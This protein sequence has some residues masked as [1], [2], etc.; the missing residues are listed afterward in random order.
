MELT[1]ENVAR[2]LGIPA[3]RIREATDD[4]LRVINMELNEKGCEHYQQLADITGVGCLFWVLANTADM[5][6]Y[7]TMYGDGP[8][9]ACH[10]RLA[11]MPGD[12]PVNEELMKKVIIMVV[13][14]AYSEVYN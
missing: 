14:A 4:E 8:V 13:E 12:Q 2:Y 7:I 11:I 5:T 9:C 1:R 10:V 3:D 6:L